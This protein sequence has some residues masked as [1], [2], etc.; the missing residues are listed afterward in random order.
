MSKSIIDTLG[1]TS[2]RHLDLF[3]SK[4]TFIHGYPTG[5]WCVEDKI[6]I[7]AA[8]THKEDAENFIKSKQC[9]NQ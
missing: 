8:F 3:E 4:G 6:E 5:K 9:Q 2:E 7:L 1:F